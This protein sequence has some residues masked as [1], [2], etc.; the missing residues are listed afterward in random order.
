MKK[1]SLE[2]EKLHLNLLLNRNKGDNYSSSHFAYDDEVVSIRDQFLGNTEILVN[3]HSR[4][5][6]SWK[7][8]K[9]VALIKKYSD[10][11]LLYL[12][13]WLQSLHQLADMSHPMFYF[14]QTNVL[15]DIAFYLHST[16]SKVSHYFFAEYIFR[17]LLMVKR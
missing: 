15:K 7:D 4:I 9:K 16:N 13:S 10:P 8:Q 14:Y 3:Q 1:I 12:G 2:S 5:D 11:V 6:G 17:F